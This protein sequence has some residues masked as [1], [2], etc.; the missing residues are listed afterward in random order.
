VRTI[1]STLHSGRHQDLYDLPDGPA[2]NLPAHYNIAPTD[3]VEVVR[4]AAN[5]AT[6]LNALA[7]SSLVVEEDA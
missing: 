7:S 5:G 1:R 3:P 4:P 6:E 2:R